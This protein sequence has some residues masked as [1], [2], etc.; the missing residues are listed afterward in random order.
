MRESD[1]LNTHGIARRSSM[2]PDLLRA[3]GR[4]PTFNSDSSRIG[5]TSRKNSAKRGVS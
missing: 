3:V 4:L 5:V 1:Q 2:R